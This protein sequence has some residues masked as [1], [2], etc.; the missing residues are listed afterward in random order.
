MTQ[1][2]QFEEKELAVISEA[3]KI[4]AQDADKKIKATAKNFQWWVAA[5]VLVCVLGFLQLLVAYF[6]FSSATY[7]EY[8]QR[9]E[10]IET[11][12]KINQELLQQNKNNQ[13]LII[14]LQKQLLIKK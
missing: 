8:F 11:T 6:Q 9:N 5:I 3:V 7:K 1:K 12:Q 13:E 2:I 14:E 4:S 10:S